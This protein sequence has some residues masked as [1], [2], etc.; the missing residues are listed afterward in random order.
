MIYSVISYNLWVLL[1]TVTP[2]CYTSPHLP[3]KAF[4]KFIIYQYSVH[5]N[6]V[7]QYPQIEPKSSAREETKDKEEGESSIKAREGTKDK[8]EGESSIKAREETKDF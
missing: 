5:R 4:T 2:P 6:P 1:N 8:E 3:T 7:V